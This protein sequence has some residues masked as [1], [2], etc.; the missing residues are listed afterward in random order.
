ML[1]LFKRL[2][3]VAFITLFTHAQHYPMPVL[4][5][6]IIEETRPVV[7]NFGVSFGP[8]IFVNDSIDFTDEFFANNNAVFNQEDVNQFEP[9]FVLQMSFRGDMDRYLYPG[10][11]FGLQFEYMFTYVDD[12]QLQAVDA[13]Q[14]VVFDFD[15]DFITSHS[16]SLTPTAYLRFFSL[17]EH[18]FPSVLLPNY[19]E[20]FMYIGCRFQ[21]NLY[22]DKAGDGLEIE[23][24][25]SFN[26]GY[27]IGI[28][29][30]WYLW[31]Q[32]TFSSTLSYATNISDFSVEVGGEEIF[33]AE[34]DLTAIRLMF[35]MH[36]YF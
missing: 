7:W 19:F 17:L 34:L 21:Y 28:G 3:V 23:D 29:T 6:E 33:S 14:N 1:S 26:I 8:R 18:M 36:Y 35:G 13:L 12:V 20:T 11:S 15:D 10:I 2:C 31:E 5:E 30:E 22:S 27:E 4:P 32:W 9:G 24:F 25:E 16:I